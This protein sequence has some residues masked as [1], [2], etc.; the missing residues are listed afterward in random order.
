MCMPILMNQEFQIAWLKI[1]YSGSLVYHYHS[2][3]QQDTLSAKLPFFQ[4]MTCNIAARI[5]A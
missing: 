4:R 2:L 5:L 3:I 1:N